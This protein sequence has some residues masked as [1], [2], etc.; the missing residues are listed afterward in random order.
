[1]FT[2]R[3]ERDSMGEMDVPVDAY[4]GAQTARAARNFQISS[5]RFS[6]GFIR[7]LGLIKK[8]AAQ[9]NMDLGQL[10]EKSL[11]M[12]TALAPRIGYDSAAAIAKAAYHEGRT[13]REIALELVGLDP[14]R[15]AARLGDP[16]LSDILRDKG[17]F[18]SALEVERL[19][20]PNSQTI[21][22]AG[23]QGGTS[24]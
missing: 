7:A 1:V 13:I 17:G 16:A 22:G 3:R 8:A 24:G 19:L 10:V 2:T 5:L 18:L 23:L 4:Y 15:V 21:R 12:C 9:V 20:D 6:R 11:A 14:D